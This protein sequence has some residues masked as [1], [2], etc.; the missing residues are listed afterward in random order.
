MGEYDYVP[1]E[2]AKPN[3]IVAYSRDVAIQYRDAFNLD[4][5]QWACLGYCQ[6]LPGKWWQRIVMMRPHWNQSVAEAI[7]FEMR[8]D[9]WRAATVA[10]SVFKL[11]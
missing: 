2:R 1:L 5:S 11:I 9:D 8:V 4:E 6:R 10:D 3:V 7:D